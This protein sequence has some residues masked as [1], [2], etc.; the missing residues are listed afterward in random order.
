ML[1]LLGSPETAAVAA[2]LAII[3]SAPPPLPPF[4]P[5]SV[6]VPQIMQ[7]SSVPISQSNTGGGDTGGMVGGSNAGVSG[8]GILPGSALTVR[9]DFKCV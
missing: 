6:P 4:V 8:G 2:P 7:L 3:A 5:Q 1:E 9:I